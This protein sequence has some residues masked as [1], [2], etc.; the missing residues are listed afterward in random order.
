LVEGRG[1]DLGRPGLPARGEGDAV[2]ELT[3]ENLPLQGSARRADQPHNPTATTRIN[4]RKRKAGQ[5]AGAGSTAGRISEGA[6]ASGFGA[7]VGATAGEGAMP[8]G[9]ARTGSGASGDSARGCGSAGGGC[10]AGGGVG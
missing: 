10:G 7:S 4:P 8:P 2:A 5:R 3:E 1:A 6:G 9:S